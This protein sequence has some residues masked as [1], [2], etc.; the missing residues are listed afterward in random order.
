M[1]DMGKR[2]NAS[3]NTK[4]DDSDRKVLEEKNMGYSHRHSL[5]EA[6]MARGGF[7]LLSPATV[8]GKRH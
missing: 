2:S 8:L 1:R 3:L 6:R 7:E 4:Y 5:K